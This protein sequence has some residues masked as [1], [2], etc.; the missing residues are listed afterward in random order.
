MS[1]GINLEV[2]QYEEIIP[3]IIKNKPRTKSLV[4]VNKMGYTRQEILSKCQERF[5]DIKTFYQA[6]INN[7]RGKTSDTKEYYTE[8]IAEFICDNIEI[9]CNSIP[10]I[11]RKSS[12]KTASHY[13]KYS[14]TSNRAEEIVAIK[15]FNQS[16]K[17][18]YIFDFIGEIIDYQIPLK[19]ERKDIAGKADLLSYD[20]RILRILELKKPDSV[21]TM[22]RCVLEGYT[23]K[24]TFDHSK[25]LLDFNLPK[26]TR[27]KSSPFVFRNGIQYKEMQQNRKWLKQLMGLLDSVP[28]YIVDNNGRYIVK[29]D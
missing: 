7:Y 13:G 17:D 23:Y 22:L 27:I 10:S 16:N 4:E 28:F 2:I 9:F 6:G 15:M 25:L 26:D 24:K 19:S 12:Y 1:L 18:G 5:S 21:E 20:G 3:K 29:E 11:T 8:V 14:P